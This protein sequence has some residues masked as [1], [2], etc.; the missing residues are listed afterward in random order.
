MNTKKAIY[1]EL[2]TI[3]GR[4]ARPLP[5][6]I[7]S[8]KEQ[9]SNF[10]KEAKRPAQP[11]R[12]V[13]AQRPAPLARDEKKQA[14]ALPRRP[15]KT[16]GTIFETVA[17]RINILER[18]ARAPQLYESAIMQ[19]MEKDEPLQMQ[20]PQRP[21]QRNGKRSPALPPRRKQHGPKMCSG[22]TAF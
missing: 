15:F 3:Y 10:L 16:E 6:W 14:P 17:D 5:R 19:K 11:Q 12:P 21:T 13:R 22:C 9:L 20:R 7:G 2:K 1:N 4:T 18:K 8:T